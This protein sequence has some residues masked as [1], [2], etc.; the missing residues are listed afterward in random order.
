VC[1]ADHSTRGV[2][3][4]LSKRDRE[5]SIKRRKALAHWELSSNKKIMHR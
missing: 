2:K 5:A 4:G 1:R 3:C